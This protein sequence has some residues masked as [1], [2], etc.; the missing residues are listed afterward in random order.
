MRTTQQ[1]ENQI[2][3]STHKRVQFS[4]QI[5]CS[6]RINPV[7]RHS[8]PMQTTPTTIQFSQH[9]Q[10]LPPINAPVYQAAIDSGATTNCFPDNYHGNNHQPT[11]ESNAILAQVANDEIIVSTAT[12]YLNEPALPNIAR[13][14]NL[15]K[16]VSVPLLSVSKL[17][18]GDLAVYSMEPRWQS[19]NLLNKPFR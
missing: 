12:D 19:S 8:T 14:T 1:N 6:K 5:N 11:T 18:A 16:E 13:E 15:F 17:C 3:T 7:T 9:A 2:R 10:S 4:D